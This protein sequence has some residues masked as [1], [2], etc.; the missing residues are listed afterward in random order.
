MK[1]NVTDRKTNN[2][3]NN[4]NKTVIK[5]VHCQL[6]VHIYFHW[7]EKSGMDIL[8]NICLCSTKDRISWFIMTWEKEWIRTHF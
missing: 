5:T 7:L 6:L 4:N 3:N 8:Q 2:K 1:V